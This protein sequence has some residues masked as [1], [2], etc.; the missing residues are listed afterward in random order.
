VQSRRDVS[1]AIDSICGYYSRFEP[2]SPIPLL[3]RRAQRLVDKDFMAIVN[4]L[5][6]EALGQ[7]KVIVGEQ[8]SS[9]NEER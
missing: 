9:T 5:T 3:L 2:S 1:R 7:L 8:V 6:P 4:D